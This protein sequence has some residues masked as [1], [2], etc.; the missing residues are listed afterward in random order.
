MTKN[1]HSYIFATHSANRELISLTYKE[2]LEINNKKDQQPM[3][4]MI[5]EYEQMFP[6]KGT[7]IN[8]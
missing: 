1:I 8:L 5:K 2:S 7:T 6:T 4:L 3:R